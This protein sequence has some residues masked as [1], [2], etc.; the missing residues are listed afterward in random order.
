MDGGVDQSCRIA[1]S[2]RFQQS[3]ID[4]VEIAEVEKG[5]VGVLSG[6]PCSAVYC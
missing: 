6:V 1:A 2:G 5:V 4:K 3:D